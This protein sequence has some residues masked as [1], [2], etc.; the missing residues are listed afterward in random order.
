[1]NLNDEFGIVISLVPKAHMESFKIIRHAWFFLNHITY[2]FS[3]DNFH[4]IA[5]F[6]KKK[7]ARIFNKNLC[8][9]RVLFKCSFYPTPIH[10]NK[11]YLIN[12][13]S[14]AMLLSPLYPPIMKAIQ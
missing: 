4:C 8:G 3:L 11:D 1:M 6:V 14:I 13:K 2:R 10:F 7:E 12:N 5:L 9:A